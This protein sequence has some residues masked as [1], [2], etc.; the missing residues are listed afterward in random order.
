M[1]SFKGPSEVA[2]SHGNKEC[3]NCKLLTMKIKILEARLAMERHPEDNACQSAAI[4][5]ELLNE[6]ENLSRPAVAVAHHRH[7]LLLSPALSIDNS[8]CHRS[9]EVMS[10]DKNWTRPT[11]NSNSVKFKLGLNAFYKRCKSH[12]ND[13][14]L[15]CCPCRMCGNREK[16]TP[17]NIKHHIDN[18]EFSRG[19]PTWV[20]HGEPRIIA[21]LVVDDRNDMINLL[22]DIRRENNCIE[23]EPNTHTEHN[24]NTTSTSNEPP[25]AAGLAKDNMEGLFEMANE[26]LFP[27]GT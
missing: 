7:S 15:C 11:L 8:C 19:Y 23:P 10:I 2:L 21:L 5:H 25:K 14:G 3:S 6:M 12:I 26:E 20:Y 18:N 17:I 27:G 13:R 24:K 16:L 1:S 9:R 4:L 22:N